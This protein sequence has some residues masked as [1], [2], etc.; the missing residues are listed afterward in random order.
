[1]TRTPLALPL[2][3]LLP[4]LFTGCVTNPNTGNQD[5]SPAVATPSQGTT[6]GQ[7]SSYEAMDVESLQRDVDAVMQ[8]LHANRD[9]KVYSGAVEGVDPDDL[10]I[11]VALVDGRSLVAGDADVRFPLMSVSK[12]F[13]YAL[14]LEQR[15]ADYMLKTIGVSATGLP[16]NSVTAGAVR[17]T[18]EQ[19]PMVNA[20][21][22]ATHLS[23]IHI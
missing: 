14:A 10:V 6:S 18:S 3:L 23:L 5:P 17:P 11:A 20:G 7:P 16:Y 9:G 8:A 12:P 4:A 2:L 19:N 15:G 1:M 13:T 22:I 21:A